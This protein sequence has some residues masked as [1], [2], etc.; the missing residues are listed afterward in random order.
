MHKI[1]ENA[2]KPK[3][4]NINDPVILPPTLDML[5]YL[6]WYKYRYKHRFL[7]QN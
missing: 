7:V 1:L 6:L 5:K 3:G 2:A 4:K